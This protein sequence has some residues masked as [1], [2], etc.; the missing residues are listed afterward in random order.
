LDTN[1]KKRTFIKGENASLE[2]I[3]LK[4]LV[5]LTSIIAEGRQKAVSPL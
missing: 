3:R 1:T 5:K 2:K 4:E